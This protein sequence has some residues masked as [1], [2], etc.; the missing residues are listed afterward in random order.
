M[1][2]Q[3]HVS[4]ISSKG[5]HLIRTR[6]IYN[7]LPRGYWLNKEHQRKFLDIFAQQFQ[8]NEPFEWGKVTTREIRDKG[9]ERL[10]A[11]HQYSLFKTLKH[12]FPGEYFRYLSLLLYL[13][14]HCSTVSLFLSY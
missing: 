13:L 3:S 5:S 10:L 11:L 8:I 9:G 7:K 4:T 2:L 6:N 1:E 12:V 14:N